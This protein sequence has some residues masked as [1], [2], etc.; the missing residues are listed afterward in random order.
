MRLSEKMF[1]SFLTIT[2]RLV[3]LPQASYQIVLHLLHIVR[4]GALYADII[5][6]Q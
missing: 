5:F 4:F 6:K 2:L 3:N 1:N